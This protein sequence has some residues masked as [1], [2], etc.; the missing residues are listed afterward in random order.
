MRCCRWCAAIATDL[1]TLSRD[2]IEHRDRLAHLSSGR[3]GLATDIYGEELS[4]IEEELEKDGRRLGEYVDELKKLGVE[5]KNPPEGL[6]DFPTI[7]DGREAFLCWKVDEPE[8][9]YWH[10]LEA[11]FAGRQSLIA[12]SAA[13]ENGHASQGGS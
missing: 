1:S 5:P 7:V 3:S 6:I 13:N 9:L 4:Q 10:E 11:G 2:I 12:E 8:L